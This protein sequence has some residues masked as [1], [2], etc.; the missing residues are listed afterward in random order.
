M[1]VQKKL[2]SESLSLRLTI[3]FELPKMLLNIMAFSD[4]Y[5]IYQR[6]SCCPKSVNL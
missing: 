3:L 1:M 2:L 6:Y 4:L 5:F